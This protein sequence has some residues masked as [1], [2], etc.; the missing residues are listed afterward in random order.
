MQMLSHAGTLWK[1]SYT[2]VLSSPELS[3]AT[4]LFPTQGKGA[5]GERKKKT[6]RGAF[7]LSEAP[8]SALNLLQPFGKGRSGPSWHSVGTGLLGKGG[9]NRSTGFSL[10]PHS[11]SSSPQPPRSA[12]ALA[13][14]IQGVGVGDF[15]FPWK[16]Q[17]KQLL[18]TFLSV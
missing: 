13:H 16:G 6:K 18:P 15:F 2:F 14:R 3:G 1:Q 7:P 17:A 8:G 9:R 11:S 10:P 5:H 12:P 4:F